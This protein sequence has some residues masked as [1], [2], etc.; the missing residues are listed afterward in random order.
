MPAPSVH[1]L[2]LSFPELPCTLRIDLPV[3]RTIMGVGETRDGGEL[4]VYALFDSEAKRTD[5]VSFYCLESGQP[6]APKAS[7][8]EYVGS[9]PVERILAG[10]DGKIVEHAIVVVHVW[11]IS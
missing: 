1:E 4:V 7:K 9:G 5:E 6:F 11:R 8:V 2:P 10:K 3:G